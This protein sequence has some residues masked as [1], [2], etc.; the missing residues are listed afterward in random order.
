MFSMVTNRRPRSTLPGFVSFSRVVTNA[1]P[2]RVFFVAEK[3]TPMSRRLR[4]AARVARQLDA[5]THGQKTAPSDALSKL[6]MGRG[7][8][9]FDCL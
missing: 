3:L 1:T 6:P 4:V 7:E 2:H 5:G 8:I 9:A